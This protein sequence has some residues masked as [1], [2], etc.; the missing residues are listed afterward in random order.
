METF[1]REFWLSNYPI[2]PG[3]NFTVAPTDAIDSKETVEGIKPIIKVLSK[4][5]EVKE[6]NGIG[7]EAKVKPTGEEKLKYVLLGQSKEEAKEEKTEKES[8]LQTNIDDQETTTATRNNRTSTEQ[9]I[10]LCHS[11]STPIADEL[12]TSIENNIGNYVESSFD[13]VVVTQND[14]QNASLEMFDQCHLM[15]PLLSPSFLQC[16]FLVEQLNSAVYRHRF[17]QRIVSSPIIVEKLELFPVY[18]SLGLCFFSLLDEFWT[19][20]FAD[21]VNDNGDVSKLESTNAASFKPTSETDVEKIESNKNVKSVS[22]KTGGSTN[23]ANGDQSDDTDPVKQRAISR[24]LTTAGCVFANILIQ[25]PVTSSSFKTVMSVAEVTKWSN[26]D[27]GERESMQPLCF[28]ANVKINSSRSVS[29]VDSESSAD[30][31]LVQ[32]EGLAEKD[33]QLKV[34]SPSLTTSSILLNAGGCHQIDHRREEEIIPLSRNQ[35]NNEENNP[36]EE[37]LS[38]LATAP[39]ATATTTLSAPIT[40]KATATITSTTPTA[41]ATTTTPTAPTTSKT[42]TLTDATLTPMSDSSGIKVKENQQQPHKKPTTKKSV[43][44]NVS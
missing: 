27:P 24:C 28:F 33:E 15:I 12:K 29:A 44:C 6:G 26:A 7:E 30:V 43:S 17:Q 19:A 21:V 11:N 23:L 34:A 32:S 41:T 39:T 31:L 9:V 36:T 40:S 5:N 14:H 13:I 3:V 8:C 20:E 35:S 16:A 25:S 22:F 1:R 18:P 2:M 10:I 38:S 4:K 37:S 42:E